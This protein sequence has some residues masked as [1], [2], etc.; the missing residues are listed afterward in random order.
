M[1][2]ANMFEINP[3]SSG[4]CSF[5]GNPA[6]KSIGAD[7]VGFIHVCQSCMLRMQKAFTI[8]Q[9]QAWLNSRAL[10]PEHTSLKSVLQRD[11]PKEIVEPLLMST[12]KFTALVERPIHSDLE[13]ETLC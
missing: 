2:L 4:S 11:Y 3:S 12:K 5:C 9:L 1:Y 8:H 7:D 6:S 10:N 13:E